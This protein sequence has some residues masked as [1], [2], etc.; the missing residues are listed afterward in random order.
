[1]DKAYLLRIPMIVHALEKDIDPFRPR[2]EGEEI[3]GVEYTFLSVIGVLMYLVN[4][5]RPDICI[6]SELYCK[7]V[8]HL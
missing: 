7:I 6:C 8:Q 2:Q 1:M 5:T 4:N 3:L